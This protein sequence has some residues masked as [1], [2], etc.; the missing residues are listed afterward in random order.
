MKWNASFRRLLVISVLS[1][2]LVSWWHRECV[3]PDRPENVALYVDT[4]GSVA[5]ELY[6]LTGVPPAIPLAV[7]GLESGWGQSELAKQGHNHFGIKARGNQARYCLE[8]TEYYRGKKHRVRDC[9]RAYPHA[10][11]SYLD[12]AKFLISQ[13]SMTACS[14][15]LRTIWKGGPTGCRSMGMPPTPTMPAS[16]CA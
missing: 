9:F 11:E 16:S 3:R 13:P 4:Y 7:G 1:W 14:A 8:T 5:R 15:S 12:F 6:D 2:L 10:E